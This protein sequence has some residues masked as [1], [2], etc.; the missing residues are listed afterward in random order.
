MISLVKE[1]FCEQYRNSVL[2]HS[3]HI[4]LQEDADRISSLTIL[5]AYMY[6]Y[7]LF[8]IIATNCKFDLLFGNY[9]KLGKIL[10]TNFFNCI[11]T[12]V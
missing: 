12:L 9:K 10:L 3:Q 1:M 7:S 11:F 5:K 2:S 6:M 8:S 4:A